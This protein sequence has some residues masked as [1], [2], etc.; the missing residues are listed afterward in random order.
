MILKVAA[1][2]SSKASDFIF[3]STGQ[4]VEE[5]VLEKTI[6]DLREQQGF[7]VK[8]VCFEFCCD[9]TK[10]ESKAKTVCFHRDPYRRHA[11][12]EL[13]LFWNLFSWQPSI[14]GGTLS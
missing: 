10:E 5:D 9:S 1:F 2:S 8:R 14:T 11:V 12:G 13:F 7:T 4:R 6:G 3:D